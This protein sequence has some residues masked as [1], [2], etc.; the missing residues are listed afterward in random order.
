MY[1]QKTPFTVA[2]VLVNAGRFYRWIR[3]ILQLVGLGEI[4]KYLYNLLRWLL[5]G[6]FV[7]EGGKLNS[8][9]VLVGFEVSTLEYKRREGVHVEEILTDLLIDGPNVV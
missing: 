6:A 3:N 9:N 7:D 8:Y 4:L 1:M 5:I 2:A